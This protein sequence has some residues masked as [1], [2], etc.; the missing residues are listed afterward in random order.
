MPF[1]L[2]KNK[3]MSEINQTGMARNSHPAQS[4][5]G[6]RVGDLAVD[7]ETFKPFILIDGHCR[8][9]ILFDLDM[10]SKY[11]IFDERSEAGWSGNGNDWTVLVNFHVAEKFRKLTELITYDSDA[12]IFSA[13]GSRKDLE[14]LGYVSQAL[15]HNDGAI[16]DLTSRVTLI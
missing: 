9:L 6:S 11:H 15:F 3:D 1:V 2:R 16:R 5:Q 4:I 10:A 7:G 13:R 8:A 14:K 12:E